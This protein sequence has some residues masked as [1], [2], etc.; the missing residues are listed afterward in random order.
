MHPLSS[1]RFEPTM[2]PNTVYRH[3]QLSDGGRKATM[4]AENMNPA[5]HPERFHFWRQ[6]LCREP[7]AGS[8]YYW[9]VEWTGQ[10]VDPQILVGKRGASIRYVLHIVNELK[11]WLYYISCPF[12]KLGY[13][14][15]QFSPKYT[16]ILKEMEEVSTGFDQGCICSRTPKMQ[17]LLQ[18]FKISFKIKSID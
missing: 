5:D 6:V 2:D 7:L 4:R 18:L 15:E 16:Q 3:V 12:S 13:K 17:H 11:S 9:E 8:P 14:N 1:V 10:K